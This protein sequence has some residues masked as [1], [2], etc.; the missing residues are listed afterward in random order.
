MTD[1]KN[2]SK[3]SDILQPSTLQ[4]AFWIYS[5]GASC[6]PAILTVNFSIAGALNKKH[7]Q[8]AWDTTISQHE[9]LRSTINADKSM[10]PLLVIREQIQ[11]KI[12]YL[13]TDKAPDTSISLSKAPAHK[14]YCHVKSDDSHKFYWHCHHA[15]LDGW[16]A[17]I[18][19]KDFLTNYKMLSAGT[20]PV[21]GD[22]NRYRRVH[23]YLQTTDTE[24]SRF[25]WREKLTGFIQPQLLTHFETA[26][27]KNSHTTVE[28][29]LLDIDSAKTLRTLCKKSNVTVAAAIQTAYAYF[30][31]LLCKQHDVVIGSAV[32]GR[33]SYIRNIDSVV[34][35][36]STVV[37]VRLKFDLTKPIKH[38]I[39]SLQ[40]ELFEASDHQHVGMASILEQ[41]EPAC[42]NK[43]FDSLLVIENFPI[44]TETQPVKDSEVPVI[45]KFNSDIVSSYPLTVT[46]IP[47]SIWKIRCDFD[48]ARLEPDWILSLQ[49]SLTE[50]IKQFTANWTSPLLRFKDTL[51][52][53]IP[54]HPE[55]KAL[56]FG[57]S[58]DIP[59]DTLFE[60]LEGPINQTE[61]EMVA[62]W[63]EILQVRPISMDDRFF[64]LGGTSLQAIKLIEQIQKQLKHRLPASIFLKNPTPKACAEAL[65]IAANKPIQCLVALKPDGKSTPLFCLHAGGGHAM[66]YRDLAHNLPTDLPCYAIQPKGIDGLEE[67]LSDIKQMA[68][69]YISEIKTL[70]PTG[71]YNLLCYCFG[72]ALMLEMA[73]QLE[74]QNDHIGHLIVADAP[75]PIPVTHPMAYLGWNAFLVYEL[76][77]HRRWDIIKSAAEV[78]LKKLYTHT[79]SYAI[80]KNQPKSLAAVQQ[81]C[82]KSFYNYRA[83]PTNLTID[84]LNAGYGN[85]KDTSAC[86]MRNWKTLAPN[87]QDYDLEINHQCIFVHPGVTETAQVVSTILKTGAQN[88]TA[89]ASPV[90]TTDSTVIV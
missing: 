57:N 13:S 69:H 80:R 81:A 48:S 67:P 68:A 77:V 21:T 29:A 2:T 50:M 36:F 78:S 41:A 56:N 84:F 65:N 7:L 12:S 53:L 33:P 63:E 1:S 72:G 30:M 49:Q 39:V 25:F 43:L 35:C 47:G 42:Q 4:R 19:L 15:L 46:I 5:G 62:Q 85:E 70:Q 28:N 11:Q 27:R 71:P 18:V 34:G 9:I 20:A 66:F 89:M 37:P 8:S 45:T 83:R 52:G 31:G 32:T 75:S 40:E 54:T 79:K 58:R 51:D 86:Y 55:E 60:H 3:V 10:E 64:D 24:Q 38:H 23:R 73:H 61:L 16:S 14:L 74:A 26:C 59:R 76:I 82:V 17:Q 44:S 6:D 87:R 22:L 88:H 90:T